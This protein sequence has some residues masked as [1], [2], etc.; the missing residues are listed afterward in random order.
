MP[1]NYWSCSKFADWIRGTPSLKSGTVKEWNEWE[2]KA[3]EKKVRYW[4][5]EAALDGVQR[6][7]YWPIDR[8]FAVRY[9]IEN[10]RK[11][12]GKSRAGAF[13]SLF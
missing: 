6:F 9:Y 4:L 11:G 3:K 12:K 8:L 5:A 1:S 10:R 13:I 2:K 7:L